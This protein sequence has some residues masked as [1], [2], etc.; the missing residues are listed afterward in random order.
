MVGNEQISTF[1]IL[2]EYYSNIISSS[3][4]NTYSLL[5]SP[6]CYFDPCIRV[7]D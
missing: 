4:I 5:A 6:Y 2:V 1:A 7:L 3:S